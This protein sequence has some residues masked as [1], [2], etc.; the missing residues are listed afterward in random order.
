MFPLLWL[1]I[2]FLAG[3]ILNG[4]IHLPWWVWLIGIIISLITAILEWRFRSRRFE[5]SWRKFAPLPVGIIVCFFFI[6]ALRF[7]IPGVPNPNDLAYYQNQSGTLT[8][9]IS[10]QPEASERSQSFTLFVTRFTNSAGNSISVHGTATVLTT[11]SQDLWF[12]D[13]VTVT[14]L[15]ASPGAGADAGY[16][17]YLQRK[18]IQAQVYYPRLILIEKGTGKS[19]SAMLLRLRQ[20]SETIIRKI[21]PQPEA[22]LVDGVLLGRAKDLPP[23]LI[24]AYQATGTAHIFAVSGFNIAIMANVFSAVFKRL[25]SRWY[26]AV[27]ALV[28]IIFYSLL[29]GGSASVVRAAIMG[30]LGIVAQMIGRRSAGIT[31]LAFTAA[32]MCLLN[33]NLPWDVSFQLSFMATLGLMLFASPLQ[34]WVEGL[35]AKRIPSE[36]A[37]KWAEPIGEYFLF[38]LAAQLMTLPVIAYHFHRL[39]LSGVLA[40]PLVLP[41]QP[42]LMVMGLIATVAGMIFIPFGRLLGYIAWPLAAYTNK[43]VEWLA[44]WG[45]N[46]AFNSIS[47]WSVL[48]F[49]A[50]IALLVI[51]Y[52]RW[53]TRVNMTASLVA[54]GL[55]TLVVWQGVLARPD[56]RLHLTILGIQDRSALLIQTPNGSRILVNSAPSSEELGS[57]LDTRLSIFDHRLKAVIL[58]ETSAAS[59]NALGSVIENLPVDAVYWG[60][61]S[62]SNA[63]KSLK[64]Q[65]TDLNIPIQSLSPGNQLILD[66]SI[67]LTALAQTEKGMA[68]RLEYND[69]NLLI[70]AG[71]AIQSNTEVKGVNLLLIG[72]DDLDA[73][74]TSDWNAIGATVVWTEPQ[75]VSPDPHWISLAQKS[76][77]EIITDGRSVWINEK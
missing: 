71:L 27:I 49:Y 28:G 40:N 23:S 21:F 44:G 25:F 55:V 63:A 67:I 72:D 15:V 56:G 77:L 35:M 41:A 70:P 38:T 53:K 74:A 12:D 47:L 46:L 57:A 9:R 64:N 76:W 2:A 17:D 1:S 24:S 7:P 30:S 34:A 14:G 13:L 29:V 18:G 48:I 16:Q 31:S 36:K 32:V 52:K 43:L 61:A 58:T 37:R 60:I 5:K 68:L 51:F 50:L 39:S 19:V 65:V 8:G 3:L 6:G 20:F 73:K 10:S 11:S 69:L 22:A 54:A 75:S 59:L 26:A 62:E 42:L 66:D 4:A 33:P 45:G